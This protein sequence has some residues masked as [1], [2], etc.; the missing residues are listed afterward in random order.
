MSKK[1]IFFYKLVRPLVIAYL[2]LKFGYTFKVAKDLPD[3]YI[4]LSNHTTD[5]DPLFLA[6]SFPRQMYFVGSEH[7]SRWK[8]MYLF[9]KYCFAPIMRPKGALASSTVIEMLRKVRG[10]ANVCLFAEGVRS[11][12]GTPSPILPST[13]KMVKSAHCGLV[14]YRITGGYFTSP[15]WSPSNNPRRGPVHGEVVHIYTP[16]QLSQMTAGEVQ[17]AIVADLA[18]DAYDRQLAAPQKYTG[19]ALAEGMENLLFLCPHCGG[20]DTLRSHGDTVSCDSCGFR[21]RYTEYGTLE[22][23]TFPTIRDFSLWQKAQVLQA[24]RNGQSYTAASCTLT[25][26]A[27]HQEFPVGQGPLS[28][29]GDSL[30]CGDIKFP[31]DQISDLAMHGKRAIVFTVQ[32]DY[33]ELIP[34][35]EANAL[36]FMLLYQAYQNKPA[37]TQAV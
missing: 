11:W 22:G 6:A 37:L 27:E 35:A 21:F 13:G 9:L 18:E 20:M 14:T 4:V 24:A 31:L 15:M 12:D 25:R 29:S 17:A 28:L 5:Y 36:K 16:E 3:T 1:H 19:K 2:W 23:E 33:Y 10:G 26:V 32:K 30:T 7:I 8:G 34:S